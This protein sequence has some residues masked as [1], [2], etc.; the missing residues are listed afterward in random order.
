MLINVSQWHKSTLIDYCNY[1][2]TTLSIIC[3]YIGCWTPYFVVHLIH[4]WSEYKYSIPDFI[5]VSA[6]T[7]ALVNSAV[8]P[9]LYGCFNLQVK[10]GLAEVC[11][12]GE[13]SFVR[14]RG[15]VSV[16]SLRYQTCDFGGIP[17]I[18]RS[19]RT[20]T[21]TIRGSSEQSMINQ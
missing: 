3:A 16:R 17:T 7:L 8:N 20:L 12:R 1:F 9:I 6:E 10:R 4:I 13:S 18:T 11:C 14:A 21:R 5:Y 19:R 2:Q 15:V